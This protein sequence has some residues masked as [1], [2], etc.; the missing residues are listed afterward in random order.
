MKQ[1]VLPD[2]C[3]VRSQVAGSRYMHLA[4]VAS[5]Y[6]F[7]LFTDSQLS[8]SLPDGLYQELPLRKPLIP[9]SLGLS[10]LVCVCVSLSLY[11]CLCCVCLP[12]LLSLS[13]LSVHPSLSVYLSLSLPLSLCSL[14]NTTTTSFVKHAS[15]VQTDQ[16]RLVKLMAPGRWLRANA[17]SFKH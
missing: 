4:S 10:V 16:F 15:C 6:L 8:S 5:E 9:R 13:C 17:D 3:L 7:R 12:P 2:L 14:I 1:L 11:V